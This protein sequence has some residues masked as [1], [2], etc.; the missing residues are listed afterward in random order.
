MGYYTTVIL[1]T[2]KLAKIKTLQDFF[3]ILNREDIIFLHEY[4]SDLEVELSYFGLEDH[5]RK[6]PEFEKWIPILV[7][8]AVF[9][10]DT[11]EIYLIDDTQLDRYGYRAYPDGRKSKL[12][13]EYRE[14]FI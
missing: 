2:N 1:P 8:L 7:K 6:N 14:E 10:N 4:Y 11:F 3:S 12:I 9:E 13:Q 5:H